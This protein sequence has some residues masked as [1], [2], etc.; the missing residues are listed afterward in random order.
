[1]TIKDILD[2]LTTKRYLYKDITKDD[3]E[4]MFFIVNRYLSKIYPEKASKFN[5]K[6]IDKSLALDMW[7]IFIGTKKSW[8]LED[9]KIDHKFFETFWSKQASIK[10]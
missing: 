1:M 6:N 3:K 2:S 7:F 9:G 4:S 5:D 8:L 10:F